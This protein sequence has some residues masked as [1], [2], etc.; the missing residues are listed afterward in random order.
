MQT[1]CDEGDYIGF[2]ELAS[3][4]GENEDEN[5]IRAAEEEYTRRDKMDT[6]AAAAM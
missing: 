3:G 4:E 1:I 6:T 5:T 2:V